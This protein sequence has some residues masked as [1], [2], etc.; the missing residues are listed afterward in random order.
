MVDDPSGQSGEDQGRRDEP[1]PVASPEP[2]DISFDGANGQGGGHG[3]Q[4]SGEHGKPKATNFLKRLTVSEWLTFL[5]GV[6]TLIVSYLTYLNA[7]DTSDIKSAVKGLADLAKQASIQA[8]QT[9]READA[10][11]TQ[12]GLVSQQVTESKKQTKAI[13]EQ[14]G[15]IK[16]SAAS[17]VSLA[18]AQSQTAQAQLKAAQ[19]DELAAKAAARANLPSLSLQAFDIG[20]LTDP[21]QK[22]GRIKATLRPRFGN[23]GGTMIA[24]G[25][26]IGFFRQLPQKLNSSTEFFAFGGNEISIPHGGTL[27]PTDAHE[28]EFSQ[29]EAAAILDGSLGFIVAGLLDYADASNQTHQWCFAYVVHAPKGKDA[30]FIP[31]GGPEWH[32]QT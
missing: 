27:F 16:S 14:T 21:P 20:G 5:V 11:N 17:A 3:A 29:S 18:N 10:L 22:D 12:L 7:T 30:Y 23:N 1:N 25:G 4:R 15:A 32:C 28:F 9:K 19:Q 24:H 2:K 8:G 13:S 31:I 26:V 6:G